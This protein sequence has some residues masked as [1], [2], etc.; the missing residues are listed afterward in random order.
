MKVGIA[1]SLLVMP[2]GC[3]IWFQQNERER[4]TSTS[5]LLYE[6]TDGWTQS[7]GTLAAE[8]P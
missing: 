7:T 8:K 5:A 4:L 1:V 3:E 6:A 2:C